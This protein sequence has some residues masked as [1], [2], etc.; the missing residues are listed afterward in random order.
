MTEKTGEIYFDLSDLGKKLVTEFE[1][2]FHIIDQRIS[3]KN[4]S[5]TKKTGLSRGSEQKR[6]NR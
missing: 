6:I 2:A 3:A 5:F 4:I 1:R